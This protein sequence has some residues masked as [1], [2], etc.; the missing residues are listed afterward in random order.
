MT[1]GDR[2]KEKR[3][4]AG[5]TQE[6]LAKATNTTRQA[7]CK[8]E[9]GSITNIPP[10]RLTLLGKVL[11]CT[12]AY[13]MGWTEDETRELSPKEEKFI[14]LVKGMSDDEIDKMNDYLSFL[15]SKRK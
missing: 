12:P 2:I 8:Y 14:E 15:L 3:I 1:I 10:S 6:E 7:I 11:N 13:I 9:K 5:L 4:E